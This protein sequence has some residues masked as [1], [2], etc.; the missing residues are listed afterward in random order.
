MG[1][2]SCCHAIRW[3]YSTRS[4]TGCSTLKSLHDECSR[5]TFTRSAPKKRIALIRVAG[6]WG[7]VQGAEGLVDLEHAVGE[8]LVEFGEDEVDRAAHVGVEVR[9][10]DD[11]GQRLE[12]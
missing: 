8:R 5:P 2:V 3:Q 11:L 12:D 10:G 1:C 7:R 9:Q 6:E 4:D